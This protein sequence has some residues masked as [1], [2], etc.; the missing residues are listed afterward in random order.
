[1][2]DPYSARYQCHSKS[3]TE[4]PQS[5]FCYHKIE[6]TLDDLGVIT[7]CINFLDSIFVSFGFV[8]GDEFFDDVLVVPFLSGV[9]RE[10]GAG[11]VGR[12]E[13]V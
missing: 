13:S 6:N 2:K 3:I 8:F 10:C 1:M 12:S 5:K 11:G 4:Q 9:H 7:Q